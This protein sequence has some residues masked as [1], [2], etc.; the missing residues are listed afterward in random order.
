MPWRPFVSQDSEPSARQLEEGFELV[1]RGTRVL[2]RYGNCVID[3]FEDLEE[4]AR[5]VA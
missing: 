4:I 3:V 5:L 1:W 2:K